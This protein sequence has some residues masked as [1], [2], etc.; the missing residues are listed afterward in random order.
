MHG[1]TNLLRSRRKPLVAVE[2]IREHSSTPRKMTLPFQSFTQAYVAFQRS[3][4]LIIPFPCSCI[5][6]AR[7]HPW[8]KAALHGKIHTMQ[9]I[10]SFLV[11]LGFTKGTPSLGLSENLKY[12][13]PPRSARKQGNSAHTTPSEVPTAIRD[14]EVHTFSHMLVN[15]VEIN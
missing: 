3:F 8:S 13:T 10:F 7:H 6:S 1:N 9:S 5:K 11:F 14:A 4:T 2:F 15:T 12:N